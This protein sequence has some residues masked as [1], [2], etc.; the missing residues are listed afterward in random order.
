MGRM[1]FLGWIIYFFCRSLIYTYIHLY[2]ILSI[3]LYCFTTIY[4]VE[5]GFQLE[6]VLIPNMDLR[7]CSEFLPLLYIIYEL[8]HIQLL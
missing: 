6:H 7:G 8:F 2:F 4:L 5:T 3:W 1:E